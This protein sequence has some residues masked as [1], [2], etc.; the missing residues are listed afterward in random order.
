VI[1]SASRAT[2]LSVAAQPCCDKLGEGLPGPLGVTADALEGLR[3][4]S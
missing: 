4:Q 1:S 2:R 3:R